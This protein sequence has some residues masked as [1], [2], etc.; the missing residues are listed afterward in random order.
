MTISFIAEKAGPIVKIGRLR[1]M[2]NKFR[3][4]RSAATVSPFMMG[5]SELKIFFIEAG[6]PVLVSRFPGG[7]DQ[8]LRKR[9]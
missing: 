6:P 7:A 5:L 2:V 4:R 1:R 8:T 3:I 9:P